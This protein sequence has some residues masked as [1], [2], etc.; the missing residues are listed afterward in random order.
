MRSELATLESLETYASGRLNV[1]VSLTSLNWFIRV[2]KAALIECG[3]LLK[4]GG[5]WLVSPAQFD[6]YV[7]DEGARA[8]ARASA[9]KEGKPTD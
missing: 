1:F 9:S 5:R 4:I 6:R 2:H 8:A 7:L 3:D